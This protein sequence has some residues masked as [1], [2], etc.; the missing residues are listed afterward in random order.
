VVTWTGQPAYWQGLAC[1]Q[2]PDDLWNFAETIWQ[3]CPKMVLEVGRGEG[4]TGEFLRALLPRTPVY[5]VDIGYMVP[6]ILDGAFVLL[7]GDVYA[8]HSMQAD[9]QRFAPQARWL[10]V[11]H[12]NRPDWGS[13]PALAAWRPEH[14]EWTP[15]DVRHP[16][17]HTWLKR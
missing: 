11:C 16:T 13:A 2:T 17:Q 15:L 6:N 12:T 9:L 10:V 5:S 14:P 7:D 1:H 8:T 3:V 4:G